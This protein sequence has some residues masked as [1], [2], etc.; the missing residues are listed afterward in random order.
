MEETMRPLRALGPPRRTFLLSLLAAAGG[1]AATFALSQRPRRGDADGSPDPGEGPAGRELAARLV[2]AGERLRITRVE[3]IPVRPR[4][5]FLKVHTDAGI[6]GLGEPIVE[7][8]SKTVAT[9]VE[10]LA[11]Y[12]VGKDPRAVAHH[13]QAMYR[14]A[15]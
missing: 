7:G 2:G 12:L 13:W 5:L 3:T 9:A 4:W 10:E 6:V 14:H 8:R 15:F 1:S 11:D